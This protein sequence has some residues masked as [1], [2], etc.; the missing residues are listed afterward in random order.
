M[1]L[2]NLGAW[3]ILRLFESGVRFPR[4]ITIGRQSMAISVRRCTRGLSKHGLTAVCRGLSRLKSAQWAESFFEVLGSER[5]DAMDC[6]PY[7]GAALIHDMND[8]VPDSMAGQYDLLYDGG[9]LEHMF[10]VPVVFRNYMKLVR[11]GGHV[12]ILTNMNNMA[13]HGFYQFGPDLFFRVFCR[14]NGFAAPEVYVAESRIGSERIYS[15]TDPSVVQMRV[16]IMNSWPTSILVV[17]QRTGPVPD[18]LLVMQSDYVKR[19]E[20]C[21]DVSSYRGRLG[22]WL[23]AFSPMLFVAACHWSLRRRNSFANR[24]AYRRIR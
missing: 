2:S 7:E 21:P 6:S 10:N 5:T 22:S 15:V 3:G 11:I 12:V 20:G 14:E 16:G 4:V 24:N 9:S 23:K 17:A 18:R 19:W 8:P 1:S 13:G